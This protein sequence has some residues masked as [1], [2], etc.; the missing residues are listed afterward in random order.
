MSLKEARANLITVVENL[1]L[2]GHP[3]NLADLFTIARRVLFEVTPNNVDRLI[4]MLEVFTHP[5]LTNV[6]NITEVKPGQKYNLPGGGTIELIEN[7]VQ[8]IGQLMEDGTRKVDL[9]ALEAF[10]NCSKGTFDLKNLAIFSSEQDL[11]GITVI[12]I[13]DD[14]F[15]MNQAATEK[16]VG[17]DKLPTSDKAALALFAV[18]FIPE[19]RAKYKASGLVAVRTSDFVACA[20]GNGGVY[21]QKC[22]GCRRHIGAVALSL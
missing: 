17:V 8:I 18:Q 3:Q 7:G 14:G 6:E 21:L 19:F 11:S 20:N 4:E 10:S 22:D 16:L 9:N 12:R 5:N 13:K 1:N 15:T 2:K